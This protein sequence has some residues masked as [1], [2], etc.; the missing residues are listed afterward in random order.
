MK[1]KCKKL[2]MLLVTAVMFFMA[3]VPFH[4]F[5]IAKAEE[6]SANPIADEIQSR[7][8]KTY[9]TATLD[10]DFADDCVLVVL[11][12]NVSNFLGLAQSKLQKLFH[13]LDFSYFN[14]LFSFPN[15]SADLVEHFNTVGYNQIIQ[16]GLRNKSKKNVLNTVKLLEKLDFV[17]SAEP[18]YIRQCD[19][20]ADTELLQDEQPY[21]LYSESLPHDPRLNEQWGLVGDYGIGANDAWKITTGSKNVRVGVIDTGIAKHEDLNANL[22]G[23]WDFY[24][25]NENAFDDK[26]QHGT[27]VAG[28]IG[29][30]ANDIGV[31]G[32]VPNV[33]L[34]SFQCSR[35]DD[36]FYDKEVIDA[37]RYANDNNISILNYSVGGFGY[38]NEILLAAATEYK[39]LFVWSAGNETK[40]VDEY[41][42]II[43]YNQA[44][45]ISVGALEN[46]S[47]RWE[48]S[49]YGKYVN[50]FAPGLDILS[51]LPNNRYG[52]DCGTSM[53]APHVT[54]TAALLLSKY[55]NLAPIEVKQ[56]ILDGAIPCKINTPKGELETRR[57]S[58]IGALMS[59]EKAVKP[60]QF[61]NLQVSSKGAKWQTRIDN[62]NNFEVRVTYNE[63]LCYE[64]DAMKFQNLIHLR[65]FNLAAGA[66][67]TVQIYDNGTAGTMTA[68]IETPYAG[69]T[70]RTVSYAY[71]LSSNG[72]MTAKYNRLLGTPFGTDGQVP[73]YVDM[74]AISKSGA[75][76]D[77]KVTNPNPYDVSITYNSKLCF[78]NDAKW[79]KGLNDLVD[80]TV[81]AGGSKIVKISDNGTAHWAT[82]AINYM[83]DGALF[84]RVSYADGLNNDGGI[85]HMNTPLNNEFAVTSSFPQTNIVPQ[86]LKFT[87]IKK[88][89]WLFPGWDVKIENPN[90]FQIQI[91]YNSKLC[92]EADARDFKNLN[93]LVT[94]TI[95]AN[96]SK[97]V[98]IDGNGTA[99]TIGMCINY[100]FSGYDYRRITYSCDFAVNS[101]K[102]LYN[103]IRFT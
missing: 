85:A 1:V 73:G 78:E 33:S 60:L 70:V 102:L 66:G 11:K 9:C 52:Y 95:P 65:T 98:T 57:L 32:V 26:R 13:L 37:I 55:P 88:N 23:G 87:P 47:R 64:G 48:L 46:N 14:D 76:Y 18:N 10:D 21:S 30:E 100:H 5:S 62:P 36:L 59:A 89:G 44:S 53:A 3:F 41:P 17:K 75:T 72:T 58:A 27:H 74:K 42:D 34:Y 91:T 92:F 97:T 80:T 8:E 22:A 24:N 94:I 19:L 39:G 6:S 63:R 45:I 67:R 81:P 4:G 7:D 86:Y 93:D 54:G 69:Q 77:I 31:S 83:I 29:A 38:D 51:T 16:I 79:F 35:D 12:Q 25:N 90:G 40:N 99:G 2:V 50:I 68:C 61:T 96:S 28:I 49:N 101:S 103:Q 71:D 82:V 43:H 84:R 15:P 20:N 56:A